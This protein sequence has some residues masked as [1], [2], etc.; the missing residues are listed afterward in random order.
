MAANKNAQRVG[1]WIIVVIMTIG[2][3]ASFVAIILMNQNQ[4]TDKQVLANACTEYTGAATAQSN[5]LSNKYFATL[6]E[7]SSRPAE[8]D[9]ATITE[10]K[11]EDLK[12]GDGEEITAESSYSAYY[13]GWGPDGKVF[14][15]S[16]DGDTLKAPLAVKPGG[17]IEGWG[18]GVVGMKVGGI[19]ELSIPSDLAYGEA[20]NSG[21]DPNTPLK[22]VM[23][24]IPTPAT[25]EI[26]AALKQYESYI[27]AGL[28]SYVCS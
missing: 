21:I 10:L 26:P 9:K 27:N 20:G 23:M 22:F 18:Q 8:Y 28:I 25:I 15:Q 13:I 7:Y 4:A 12:V 24:V 19:R 1:I 6:N 14:D 11:S 17:V 5:E 16:I 3:L 2:T